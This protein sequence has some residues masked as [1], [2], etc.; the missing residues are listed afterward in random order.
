M[1]FTIHYDIL[2]TNT[3][4]ISHICI[5][6]IFLHYVSFYLCSKCFYPKQLTNL[7]AFSNNCSL[8]RYLSSYNATGV[9]KTGGSEGHYITY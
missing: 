9:T 1:V 8:Q 7:S 6:N 5:L 2:V 3:E 4:K